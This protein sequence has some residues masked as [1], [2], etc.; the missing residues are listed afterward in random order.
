MVVDQCTFETDRLR[1]EPW[2]R[3]ATP[4]GRPV[5]LAAAVADLLTEAVTRDLPPEWRG[6][7]TRAR[8][9]AWIAER[10]A[11]SPT[12]L[13]TEQSTGAPAGLVILFPTPLADRADGS[14]PDRAPAG[15]TAEVRLGYLLAESGWGRGLAT[16]L[17]GGLIRWC[18]DRPHIGALVGGV[19]PTNTASRRVLERAGFTADQRPRHPQAEQQIGSVD[20]EPELTYRLVLGVGATPGADPDRAD[21]DPSDDRSD[22]DRARLMAAGAAAVAHNAPLGPDRARGLVDHLARRHVRTVVDLGCG[23]GALACL[24][25]TR[26]PAVTV[27]GVDIA[28]DHLTEARRSAADRGLA[29]R[30][31]F[32]EADAASW[33]P[34]DRRPDAVVCVGAGHALGGP[35]PL[36]AH[37]AT[38]APGGTA[39]VGDGVWTAAPDDWC[40]A[41]FGDL[42]AGPDGLAALA[43]DAGWTV[44]AADVSTL[45]EWDAFE[46]GWVGGVRS[47]GTPTALDFAREREREYQRYRG[48]LGFA[49]LVLER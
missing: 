42:P 14:D 40:R 16:E 18:R 22:D 9:E 43:V 15:P 19:A 2:H 48:V 5:D 17:V 31:R 7:Y 49:W 45:D 44:A 41:T 32:V 6:P 38:M 46:R 1:V 28:P 24:V 33:T 47:I 8:A 13:V 11:E 29:S 25:A 30:V 10:D 27:T 34:A 12:L 23:R 26:L 3:A 37:L 20:A 36:L 4:D 21:D 39:V 35:G